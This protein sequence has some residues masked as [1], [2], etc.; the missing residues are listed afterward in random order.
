[1]TLPRHLQ[2]RKSPKQERSRQLVEAIVEATARVL[3]KDGFD[4]LSVNDVADVAGV[5]VG[6]LYQYFPHKEALVVAV[7][8]R[9]ADSEAAYLDARFAQL[10][11]NTL[12]AFLTEAIAAVL[13]YRADHRALYDALLAVIPVVGRFY[14]LRARSAASAARTRA[15]L[16][17]HLDGAGVDLD[18]V[19]YVIVNATHAITHEGLLQ[20]PKTLTDERLAEEATRVVLAYLQALRART[21]R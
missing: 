11:S 6:S 4:G 9:E 18:E 17:T 14:D 21:A 10:T 1:M 3:V 16:A 2:P 7:L 19:T 8:E 15:I 12:E 13:A 5:S 20:R